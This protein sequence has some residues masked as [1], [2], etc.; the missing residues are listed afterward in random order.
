MNSVKLR[1]NPG[2]KN[3]RSFY[4]QITGAM[5]SDSEIVLDFSEVSQIELSAVHVIMIASLVARARA[6]VLR[7]EHVPDHLRERLRISEIREHY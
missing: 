6:K 7:L 2:A 3:I 1:R 4:R 5:D